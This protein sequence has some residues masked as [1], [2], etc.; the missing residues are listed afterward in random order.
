MLLYIIYTTHHSKIVRM[1]YADNV[2][3]DQHAHPCSLIRELHCPLLW[4]I[5]LYW[6]INGHYIYIAIRTDCAK[7]GLE[8]HFPHISEGIFV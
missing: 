5:A 6:L 7:K 2:A 1:S 4:K 3:Q 8:V